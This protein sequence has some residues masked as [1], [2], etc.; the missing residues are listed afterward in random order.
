MSQKIEVFN[1]SIARQEEETTFAFQGDGKAEAGK[2]SY[3]LSRSEY[4]SFTHQLY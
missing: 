1:V 4:D 2:G 3:V